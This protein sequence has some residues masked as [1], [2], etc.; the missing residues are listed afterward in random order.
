[1]GSISRTAGLAA[2]ALALSGCADWPA[3]GTGGVA[4]F[5]A[6]RQPDA[7]DT[8]PQ[9]LARYRDQRARLDC[10]SARVRAEELEARSRSTS[11]GAMLD[12]QDLETAARRDL[13]GGLTWD[14]S[15]D[16]DRLDGAVAGLEPLLWPAGTP[17]R[18]CGR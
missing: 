3:P 12:L 16:L 8:D 1:M 6:A 9:A 18:A 5:R 11:T 2:L 10:E 4:E 13:A 17:R 7:T 14:A 15:A